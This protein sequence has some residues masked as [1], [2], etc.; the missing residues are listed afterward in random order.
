GMVQMTVSPGATGPNTFDLQF[1]SADFG[2]LE[3]KEVRLTLGQSD[4]GIAPFM[5]RAMR[6]A[7]GNWA[8][9]DVVVPFAG[10]WQ[11][12]VDAYV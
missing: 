2:P 10:R 7:N 3:P 6:L 1:L 5:R 9:R 4:R 11:V 12:T 8:A